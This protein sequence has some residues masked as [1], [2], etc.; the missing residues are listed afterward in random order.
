[1]LE[2]RR[3]QVGEYLTVNISGGYNAPV[4]TRPQDP[5]LLT[6]RCWEM[7]VTSWL[8][9]FRVKSQELVAKFQGDFTFLKP[10]QKDVM[11]N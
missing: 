3:K 7:V 4:I 5:L 6:L 11:T 2:T 8:V 1:M 9:R 10:A